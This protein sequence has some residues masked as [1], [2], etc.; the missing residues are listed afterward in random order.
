MIILKHPSGLIKNCPNGYS[1][2]C[3][4]FGPFV[5][6]IRGMNA[7]YCIFL[8]ILQIF[9]YGIAGIIEGFFINKRYARYLIEKGYRASSERDLAVPIFD[10]IIY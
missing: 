10:G 8:L 5:A 2:T 7:G 1:W 4:F 6:M 3:L 9:T